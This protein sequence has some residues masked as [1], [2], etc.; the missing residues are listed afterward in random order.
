MRVPFRV[1]LAVR[2]FESETAFVARTVFTALLNLPR[3]ALI[4]LA[5]A[6]LLSSTASISLPLLGA[7]ACPSG[8]VP[9]DLPVYR[10]ALLDMFLTSKSHVT[11]RACGNTRVNASMNHEIC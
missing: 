5:W 9:R 1:R 2:R 6:A 10:F 3:T 8:L 4:R 11:V 7:S